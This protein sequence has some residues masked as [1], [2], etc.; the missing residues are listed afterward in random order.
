MRENIQEARDVFAAYQPLLR[1]RLQCLIDMLHPALA[2]DVKRALQE[3]GKLLSPG[4][5]EQKEHASS[6]HNLPNGVWSL[7]PLLIALHVNPALN[8][9]YGCAVGVAVECVIC[10]LDLLDDVEDGDQT[11]IVHALGTARVLNVA[12]TLLSLAQRTLLVLADEGMEPRLVLRLLARMHESLLLATA[13]QHRDLLDEQRAAHTMTQE[14]CLEI[15]AWKAGALMQMACCLGALCGQADERT[16]SLFSELG[17]LLG[18]AHQ[19]DNDSHDLYH[20]LVKGVSLTQPDFV[21][22]DRNIRVELVKTDLSRSKKTL[23]VV[24]AATSDA[25]LQNISLHSDQ[26]EARSRDLL[27]EGII[28]TW[29]LC[30][31]YRERAGDYLYQIEEHSPISSALRLLFGST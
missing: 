22:I 18:I 23:P 16:Y 7:L 27:H 1:K 3:P 8:L 12:T 5:S 6:L 30:L 24:I 20:L 15:A 4:F 19:L 14:E 10:A 29:G 13:G 17:S 25:M 11:S 31:L 9:E 28:T 26:E 2:L 21:G